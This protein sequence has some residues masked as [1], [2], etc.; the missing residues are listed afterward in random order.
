MRSPSHL[1]LATAL[2]LA[3]ACPALADRRNPEIDHLTVAEILLRD[4]ALE[5]ADAALDQADPNA[6]GVDL[7]R[8]WTL[9]GLIAGQRE[10]PDD[11]IAAFQQALAAGSVEPMVSIYLAQ[12]YFAR[13]N[14]A[15][16]IEVL[17]RAGPAV[18]DLSAAWSMRIHANWQGGKRQRALDLTRQ[19]SLR[20]PANTTFARRE[21][22]YLLE[23]G[24]TQQAAELAR[25]FL[26]RAE[27]GAE[28]YATVG[29]ALRRA[30]SYPEAKRIL[31]A[32]RLRFVD[33]LNLTKAL[34]QT[35]LESG[36]V[37][38]AAVV[39][40]G[41][42]R[43]DPALN[44]ETAELYRR[45]GQL[46]L[47]LAFNA[48]IADSPKKLKQRVG[49]LAQMRRFDEIAAMAPAI[50]RAGLLGD[51]DVRYALAFAH[52]RGGDFERAELELAA[53]TRPDLFRKATELRRLISEC[54]DARWNCG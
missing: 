42:A 6:A 54:A 20:F 19:A 27:V 50:E 43:L 53:L 22:F 13:E 35:Y 29:N 8:F 21:V 40:E 28:D 11:A 10:Q 12:S 45:A 39:L 48:R 24:L 44:P 46:A 38:A 26:T 36:D 1:L 31:E 14:W 7:A 33:D 16:V 30:K 5:R 17:E 49:I 47:A 18:D 37:L 23:L 32:A 51:Q 41:G 9:K 4:G 15:K 3:V 34:A 52:F 2:A 25:G